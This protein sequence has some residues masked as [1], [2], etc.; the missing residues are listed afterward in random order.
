M[1]DYKER[2]YASSIV[3][4][5]SEPEQRMR[6]ALSEL[7]TEMLSR[8]F[9]DGWTYTCWFVLKARAITP[10]PVRQGFD[11]TALD[12]GVRAQIRRHAF[13]RWRQEVVIE[14][15][16]HAPWPVPY[17][18]ARTD[19]FANR[20]E[21]VKRFSF[22]RVPRSVVDTAPLLTV[23]F[24][25]HVDRTQFNRQY[26]EPYDLSAYEQE[27]LCAQVERTYCWTGVREIRLTLLIDER[28]IR[29]PLIFD[30]Y[31]DVQLVLEE[32][33][34]DGSREVIT[35]P[36]EFFIYKPHFLPRGEYSGPDDPMYE[37]AWPGLTQQ[38]TEELGL[39]HTTVPAHRV[40]HTFDD[41]D[42]LDDEFEDHVFSVQ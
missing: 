18:M 4:E 21:I 24:S 7:Q 35:P 3:L 17:E 10:P 22:K 29:N 2:F 40:A 25:L 20:V 30:H 38:L 34:D 37:P 36:K 41:H 33:A 8:G 39:V 14:C 26:Q 42:T 1:H 32:R 6:A 28:A 12:Q 27:S 9:H 16:W 5:D 15:N 11:W 13:D 23:T 19:D 31:F